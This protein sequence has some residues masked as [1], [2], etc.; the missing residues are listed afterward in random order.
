MCAGAM[1]QSRIQRLV[2]GA[3]EQVRCCGSIFNILYPQLTI[4]ESSKGFGGGCSQIMKD[5]RGS[6]SKNR[7]EVRRDG[8]V[9]WCLIRNR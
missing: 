7:S 8:R 1:V 4:V 3:V 9:W 6:E 2:F 5:F